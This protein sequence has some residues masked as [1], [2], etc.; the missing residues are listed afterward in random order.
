MG[1]TCSRKRGEE[2]VNRQDEA[3]GL[4]GARADVAE[5]D[6]FAVEGLEAVVG[7][8]DAMDVARQVLGGVVAVAGMLEVDGPGLAED[9]RIEPGE[10][11]H[12]LEAV[13]HLG[14]EDLREG[15]TGDEE[16]A[17]SRLAP[18][19]AVRRQSAGGD[20]QVDV[21]VGRRS[22]VIVVSFPDGCLETIRHRYASI[23]RPLRP[24]TRRG[25]GLSAE[26]GLSPTRRCRR[27]KLVR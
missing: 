9:P 2:G 21:G 8:G 19:L 15:V 25:G 17:V 26:G 5:G 1:R 20:Q 24:Q 6:S 18:G 23:N 11:V 14:A 27:T 12:A 4:T 16:A 13:A 3:T 10:Q 7:Q 22:G